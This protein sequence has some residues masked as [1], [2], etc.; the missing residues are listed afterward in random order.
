MALLR[1]VPALRIEAIE[2]AGYFLEDLGTTKILDHYHKFYF[3]FNISSIESNYKNLL[4]NAYILEARNRNNNSPFSL[5]NILKNNC[6]QIEDQLA[7]FNNHRQ[8]RA[9]VNALGSIVRYITGNLDQDDLKEINSNLHNL[10]TNQENIVKQ[11]SKFSSFAN[12]ITQRYS[13]DLNVLR[14]NINTSLVAIAKINDRLNEE[15]LIEYNILLSQKLLETIYMIQR[16]VSLAF[17]NITDLEIISTKELKEMIDHLKLIYKRDELLELDNAHLFKFIEFSKMRIISVNNTITC[18]L[19]IPILNPN[20]YTYQKVYPLPDTDHKLLLPPAKYRLFNIHQELWT[21]EECKV[22]ESQ[23]LCINKPQDSDCSL[24]D[25]NLAQNCNSVIAK[26]NYKIFVKLDNNKIL[27]SCKD[28]F[29]I[30]EECNGRLYHYTSVN[31]VLISSLSNCRIMINNIT[32][33][34]NYANFTY[35][36]PKIAKSNFKFTNKYVHLEQKHIEDFSK[37]REEAKELNKDIELHPIVHIAHISVTLILFAVTSCVIIV[38]I[39]LFR[40]KIIRIFKVNNANPD[41][42]HEAV[43]IQLEE[44]LYPNLPTAPQVEDALS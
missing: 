30:V 8:K 20:P 36:M 34:N 43:A 27:A 33:D 25:S 11:I 44:K 9:L 24:I 6:M 3:Y 13:D 35:D 22:V 23:V 10:F 2:N 42:E 18:I 38:I 15:L 40:R 29:K 28:K 21:N 1:M 32:Y 39:Y 7:K 31:N 19:Y 16:L 12:H 26:N 14:Q 5:I 37:I 17:N 4:S 41:E